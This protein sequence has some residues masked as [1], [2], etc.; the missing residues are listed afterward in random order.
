MVQQELVAASLL[1]TTLL[2]RQLVMESNHPSSTNPETVPLWIRT[3][4]RLDRMA[5]FTA[6]RTPMSL[7]SDELIALREERIALASRELILLIKRWEERTP[8]PWHHEGDGN[9]MI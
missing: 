4:R 5:T 3:K 9:K 7:G 6:Q 2:R 1:F 8:E